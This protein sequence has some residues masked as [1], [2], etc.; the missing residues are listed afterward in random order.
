MVIR[1]ALI[2]DT[3]TDG[4]E[5]SSRV[6]EVGAV[7]YDVENQSTLQEVSTLLAGDENEAEKI[8]R[9]KPQCL[10]KMSEVGSAFA[11][12]LLFAMSKAADVYVA[13]NADF[14]RARVF[15]KPDF[16]PLA[17]APWVDSMDFPWPQATREQ[18]SL[19]NL[20]LD[21]GIGVASAHRALTDCRL[22][23][24]LFNRATD[25][26]A[27][28]QHAMRPKVLV[29]GCQPFEQNDLARTAGFKWDR[30]VPRRWSRYIAEDDIDS[31]PFRVARVDQAAQGSSHSSRR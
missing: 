25:L 6:I 8:N 12:E 17:N 4:L 24:E 2:L 31:L 19:V 1:R 29:V 10:K 7:L 28:F 11:L 15:G 27:M 13:H 14:D 22:I 30:H 23:A 9:I 21:H 5:E 26:Q 20:A 16:L 18:S 3:E